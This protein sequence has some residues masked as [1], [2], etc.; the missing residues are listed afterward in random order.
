[1]S[2]PSQV[3]ED[4][5]WY[6]TMSTAR[7]HASS[8]ESAP[9]SDGPA[10]TPLIGDEVCVFSPDLPSPTPP[11]RHP[12]GDAYDDSPRYHHH[13]QLYAAKQPNVGAAFGHDTIDKPAARYA[14]PSSFPLVH[15]RLNRRR[16]NRPA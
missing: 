15:P 11:S 2:P 13:C 5:S 7:L 3:D 6:A 14:Q 8:P 12:D 16:A 1:M 9:R 4:S 10:P